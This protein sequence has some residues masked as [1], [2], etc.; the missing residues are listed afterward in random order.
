VSA[1]NS[2][3]NFEIDL[4]EGGFTDGSSNPNDNAAWHLETEGGDPPTPMVPTVSIKR[5]RRF[6]CRQN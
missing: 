4:E 2:G 5:T 6:R 1:G 3:D